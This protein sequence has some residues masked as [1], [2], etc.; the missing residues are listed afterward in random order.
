MVPGEDR[1]WGRYL[2][3]LALALSGVLW[4]IGPGLGLFLVDPM[5]Q[6]NVN[7]IQAR[8]Q[9]TQGM[10]ACSCQRSVQPGDGCADCSGVPIVR[11]TAPPA[12]PLRS[13]GHHAAHAV[14]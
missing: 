9:H 14:L 4:W 3:V 5:L 1:S 13:A 11:G 7:D 10:P 2:L 12:R 8:Q 6:L